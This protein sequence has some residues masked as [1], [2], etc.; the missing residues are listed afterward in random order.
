M[1]AWFR[2]PV[3]SRIVR[4]LHFEDFDPFPVFRRKVHLLTARRTLLATVAFGEV[5][6]HDESLTGNPDSRFFSGDWNMWINMCR[7]DDN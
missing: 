6:H 7:I 2:H 3:R 1:E 4:L 5:D